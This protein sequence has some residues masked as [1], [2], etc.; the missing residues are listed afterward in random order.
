MVLS[1]KQ[2]GFTIVELLTVIIVIG[3]LATITVV[4]YNG[5]QDRATDV[6]VKSDLKSLSEKIMIFE[7]RNGYYPENTSEL[8]DLEAKASREAYLTEATYDNFAYCAYHPDEE[9]AL[10]AI[11]AVTKS[12]KIFY[13]YSADGFNTKVY[14]GTLTPATTL[15]DVCTD[16]LGIAPGVSEM[17]YSEATQSWAS[18]ITN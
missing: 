14:A 15:N 2:N 12:E 17:G 1:E 4:A 10:V 11:G 18:W 5:I 13:S 16:I 3:I 7:S 8:A 9:D 6:S